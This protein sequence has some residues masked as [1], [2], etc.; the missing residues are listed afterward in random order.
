MVLLGILFHSWIRARWS[1]A[2]FGTLMRFLTLLSNAG[3]IF[4]VKRRWVWHDD[5]LQFQK[6]NLRSIIW[7][8]CQSKARFTKI[9]FVFLYAR[10][11]FFFPSL[12][13]VN[14]VPPVRIAGNQYNK[15]PFATTCGYRHCVSIGTFRS[16]LRLFFVFFFFVAFLF[17]IFWGK[18]WWNWEKKRI[19]GIGNGAEFRPSWTGRKC[20]DIYFLYLKQTL[21][22]W[23]GGL[24]RCD[25]N[26]TEVQ[27][28]FS[29]FWTLSFSDL[30]CIDS[31]YLLTATSHTIF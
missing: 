4:A 8:V 10:T 5:Y 9:I 21:L 14:S 27:S 7:L 3:V 18:L 11:F 31:G 16:A 20:P 2:T 17:F 19:F 23:G 24:G 12:L 22:F 29:T 28:I 26:F 25:I 30:K 1:C 6:H 13:N 15:Q